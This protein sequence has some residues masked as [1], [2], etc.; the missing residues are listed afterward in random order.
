MD[1][2][3][4]RQKKSKV[5]KIVTQKNM[6]QYYDIMNEYLVTTFFFSR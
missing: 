5:S 4:Y 1:A 2:K 3:L 6:E